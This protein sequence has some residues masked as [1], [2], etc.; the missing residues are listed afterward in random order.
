MTALSDGIKPQVTTPSYR[1]TLTTYLAPLRGRATVLLVALLASIGLQL[2]VPQ[3]LARFID[4][5]GSR[6][7]LDGLVGIGIRLRAARA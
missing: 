6:V 4:Q 7:A 2:V 3:L 5:V 1:T